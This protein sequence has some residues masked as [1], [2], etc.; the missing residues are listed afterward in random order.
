MIHQAPT[1][2]VPELWPLIEDYAV[3]AMRW[4]PFMDAGDLL[5]QLLHGHAQ[6]FVVTDRGKDGVLG[7]AAVEMLC[8]PSRR[9]ANV[10]AAG[11]RRGF[12]GAL[13][14]DLVP[15]LERW[16]IEQGAD[17][18]CVQGRPGWLKFARRHEGVHFLQVVISQKR[19][20]NGGWRR[21]S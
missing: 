8:Y 20:G 3:K 1:R 15:Q 14:Q 7:F 5:G 12:L 10:L 16:A 4:H 6:L 2:L 13:V 11:G 19:L 18:F 17:T 21:H 9:I